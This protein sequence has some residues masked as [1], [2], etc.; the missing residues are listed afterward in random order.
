M[1]KADIKKALKIGNT[2]I[3]VVVSGNALVGL[4]KYIND[5]LKGPLKSKEEKQALLIIRE[6]IETKELDTLKLNLKFIYEPQ[7][8]DNG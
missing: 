4:I 7:K 6:M 1:K 3:D 8:K 5:E 2:D